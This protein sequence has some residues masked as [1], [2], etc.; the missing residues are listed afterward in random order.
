[1]K[2]KKAI[3]RLLTLLLV[4][5]M[6]VTGFAQSGIRVLAAGEDAA[7]T[8]EDAVSDDAVSSDDAATQDE[9]SENEADKQDITTEPED[10][11]E[12]SEDVP[13]IICGLVV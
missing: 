3:N 6:S 4:L 5:V 10:T 9:V 11:D 1:M 2:S 13:L 12:P 8:D 7:V